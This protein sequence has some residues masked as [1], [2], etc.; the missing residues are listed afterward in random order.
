MEF[1]APEN[2]SFST[3]ASIDLAGKNGVQKISPMLMATYAF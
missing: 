3:G 1:L 2:L